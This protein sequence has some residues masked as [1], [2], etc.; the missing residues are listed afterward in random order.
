MHALRADR[1]RRH[2]I[3]RERSF[4]ERELTECNLP[5][6]TG[7]RGEELRQLR[8]SNEPVVILGAVREGARRR[9]WAYRGIAVEQVGQK[10]NGR[11]G[12]LH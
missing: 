7:S 5:G 10:A 11:L 6:N 3:L 2:E 12:E 1:A 4:E 9:R 8:R